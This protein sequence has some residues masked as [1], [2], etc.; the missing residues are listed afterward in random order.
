M[1]ISL[2]S[3]SKSEIKFVSPRHEQGAG[4]MVDVIKG[5]NPKVDKKLGNIS[6]IVDLVL[7]NN[8]KKTFSGKPLETAI[9]L[10]CAISSNVTLK[11]ARLFRT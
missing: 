10:V 1:V 9:Y 7:A 11:R 8:S 6:C 2:D 3:L 4:F 5:M